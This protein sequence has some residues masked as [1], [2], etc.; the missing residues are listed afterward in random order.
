MEEAQSLS[1]KT[2]ENPVGGLMQRTDSDGM[3]P[4]EVLGNLDE[5]RVPLPEEK[6]DQEMGPSG[7]Q[8]LNRKWHEV[9]L[10]GR[11]ERLHHLWVGHSV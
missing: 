4:C 9:G 11:W 7:W 6:R 2:K 10:V 3:M 1:F 5:E 8:G